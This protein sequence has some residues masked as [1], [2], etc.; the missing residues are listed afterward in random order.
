MVVSGAAGEDLTAEDAQHTFF[1]NSS[2]WQ[3][4]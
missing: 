3:D 4:R 2:A 1:P